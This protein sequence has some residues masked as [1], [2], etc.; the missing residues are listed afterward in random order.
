MAVISS[1]DEADTY[2]TGTHTQMPKFQVLQCVFSILI[3][4]VNKIVVYLRFC[5]HE[6]YDNIPLNVIASLICTKTTLWLFISWAI[7][8]YIKESSKSIHI[9]FFSFLWIFFETLQFRILE[10]LLSALN[11]DTNHFFFLGFIFKHKF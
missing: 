7:R 10:I 2:D 11:F 6:R 3:F 5:G 4:C 9:I 1:T 8:I